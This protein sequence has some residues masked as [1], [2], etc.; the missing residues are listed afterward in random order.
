MEIEV[1]YLSQS[2]YISGTNSFNPGDLISIG[3]G[4]LSGGTFSKIRGTLFYEMD[5]TFLH[6]NQLGGTLG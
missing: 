3:L 4:K 2:Q 6:T 5:E 1:I